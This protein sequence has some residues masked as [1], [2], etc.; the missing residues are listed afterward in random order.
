[1]PEQQAESSSSRSSNDIGVC[2]NQ[3]IQARGRAPISTYRVQMHARFT[4]ANARAILGYLKKLGIGDLYSSPIFEAR[5]GSTHGYDVTR[6]DRLNPELGGNEDFESLSA[7]LQK[8]GM[9]LLLDIVPN[10]MGVGNDSIWWQDVLENGHAS[11]YS[12]YF[13]IDWHPLKPGMQNKLL[14]PILGNQYGIELE[15]KHLQVVMKDGR[16][17]I[18]YYGHTMPLAPRSLPILF[19]EQDDGA[20]QVPSSFRELLNRLPQIP[21]HE[22]SD[23]HLREQRRAQ[24]DSL[25]PQLERAFRSPEMQPAIRNA[26]QAINGIEGDPH[27]FDRLHSLLEAQPYRL[28]LWRTS[29]EEIN[30]RR[31]FDVNDLVGLRME[32]PLVFAETHCLVRSLLAKHQVTGL[33]IDHCDGMFNPRQYLIRLQ[34]LYLASQCSGEQPEGATAANGIERSI[35]DQV[36][37]YDWS[38]SQGAL[39]TVVE[40]ILEPREYLPSSWPVRGT[41]GYDFIYLANG[42]FIQSGNERRFDK[43]YAQILGH[44]SDPDAIIYRSKA[45]VMQTSLASD[46]YAL[47]NLLSRIAAANRYARDFTDNLLETA[48]RETIASFPVYRTY[49]DDR[50][51]YSERD[52][53][54]IRYAV[55]RAKRLNPDIDASAFDFLRDTLLLKNTAPAA[56][57]GQKPDPQMLYFALKFQQLTGPVMAKG[58][59]DTAFYVYN[60][61]LSSNEVGGSIKSFGISL[62]TLHQSNGERLRHSPDSMLASSTHDTKRSEDVRNRLNVL[63]EMPEA[64]SS[65]VLR[66]Q[67]MNARFKRTLEDGRVAPDANEEYLLYQTIVGAWPWKMETAS[68][69]VNF[70]ERIKE[71]AFKA[72]S[73]AKVN[74]SWINPDQAYM[75][76]VQAFIDAILAPAQREGKTPFV[77]SLAQLV[78][79]LRL[80]GAINSL[81]QVVLKIASPGVP[82]FY[83]GTELWDLSLVDPDNRRPVDYDLR[84]KYLESMIA[85]AE[86]AGLAE[87]CRDVLATFSD[88]RAKLWTMHRSLDLRSRK[89]PVFQRGEYVSLNL[90]GS[91]QQTHQEHVIAFL[92]RDP[93]IHQSVLAIVPRF[94]FTLMHGKL[95]FPLGQAWGKASLVLPEQES[96]SRYRNVFTGEVLS[97]D[98]ERRLPL[99]AAFASFPVALLESQQ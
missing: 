1:M 46:V 40:K 85:Q 99:S 55:A 57:P 77:R 14:L 22:T 49:I 83:Q 96:G 48:L 10:H 15:S 69:A 4:F 28:A 32:N 29:A 72:L 63:S 42:I 62:D 45:Q 53:A 27:S 26:L 19:P 71:Y 93:E 98:A 25:L 74:L 43:L 88:G 2:V 47:T 5:P 84:S 59:E 97:A 75:E 6:H 66:W 50:G 38:R 79:R 11:V 20:N 76:A 54:F 58:V 68:D 37:G 65:T 36:R 86:R 70:C 7:A 16:P 44:P 31:F 78:A 90:G 18:E 8:Q 3:V 34:L 61:F 52:V 23:E 33:R 21:P 81:A 30:Y 67:R 87:V 73:E 24:L 60:R 91:G 94:T 39:Y 41:S 64:W 35:L 80:F 89:A 56:R 51:E 92:R 12:E 13:D 95:N 17:L 82:D 9:G